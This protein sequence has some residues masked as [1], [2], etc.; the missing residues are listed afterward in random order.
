MS[1]IGRLKCGKMPAM[2]GITVEMFN[3]VGSLLW[4]GCDTY[5]NCIV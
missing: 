5:V 1:A 3:M 2:D 4:N